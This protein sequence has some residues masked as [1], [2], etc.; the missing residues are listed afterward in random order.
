MQTLK[1]NERFLQPFI[2]IE[3]LILLINY[4]ENTKILNKFKVK[5][6]QV[7]SFQIFVKVC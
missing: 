1:K 2:A 4:T 7:I 3:Y 5:L 6:R